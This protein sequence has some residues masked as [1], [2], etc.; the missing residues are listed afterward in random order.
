MN[1][2][3]HISVHTQAQMCVLQRHANAYLC[4]HDFR[5][6]LYRDVG[7]SVDTWAHVVTYEK[8]CTHLRV[9]LDVAPR[10]TKR[11][12]QKCTHAH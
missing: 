12:D 5:P 11:W 7:G 9:H 10:C 4:R 6:L 2:G 3:A 8:R 1:V